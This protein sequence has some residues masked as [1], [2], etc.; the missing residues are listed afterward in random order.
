MGP[1]LIYCRNEINVCIPLQPEIIFQLSSRPVRG[2][3][4]MDLI[5][6]LIRLLSPP[7]CLVMSEVATSVFRD[8]PGAD[9]KSIKCCI[10]TKL[11]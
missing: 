5:T 9:G 6:E 4:T 1:E 2:L 11:C 3:I 7:G 8:I 10:E